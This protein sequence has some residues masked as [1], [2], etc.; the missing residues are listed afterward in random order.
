LFKDDLFSHRIAEIQV[1]YNCHIR[2]E[3]RVKITTSRDVFNLLHGPWYETIEHHESFGIIL[4]AR[5]NSV[6]G[7]NWVSQG[8]ISGTVVD[9]RM[10][11]QLAL[12]CCSTSIIGIHNHPSGNPLPSG[13]DDAIT[14]KIKEAGKLLD[15]PLI[16]HIILTINNH[17]SYADEGKL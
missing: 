9:V 12:K 1:T 16:D 10:I 11:F 14:N 15:I 2:P 8:G 13:A 6:L 7:I 4:L 5:D 3:N 17:Y